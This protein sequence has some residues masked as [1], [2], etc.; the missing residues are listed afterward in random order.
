LGVGIVPG[1]TCG[2]ALP[3]LSATCCIYPPK[4]TSFHY[5]LIVLSMSIL[6]FII[7]C[8]LFVGRIAAAP[9][10]AGLSA[11]AIKDLQLALFLENLELALL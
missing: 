9:C 8:A 11:A 1:Q 10:P 4:T 2:Q 7:L 3:F 5:F 6:N